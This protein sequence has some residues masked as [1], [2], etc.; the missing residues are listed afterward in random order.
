LYVTCVEPSGREIVPSFEAS[1]PAP[2]VAEPVI[3]RGGHV[4]AHPPVHALV[5]PES[6]MNR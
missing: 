5:P 1:I 3:V 6:F 2:A 4:V